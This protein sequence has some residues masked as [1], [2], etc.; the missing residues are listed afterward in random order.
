M[1]DQKNYTPYY[2]P[3]Q[4]G[5][6]QGFP[7]AEFSIGETPGVPLDATGASRLPVGN[8]CFA[9]GKASSFAGYPIIP[10]PV[11]DDNRTARSEAL[12]KTTPADGSSFPNLVNNGLNRARHTW[13]RVQK[14]A[15]GRLMSFMN[16][17]TGKNK[18]LFRLDL[19]SAP[20]CGHALREN[21]QELR[22]EIENTFGLR[23]NYVMVE[24]TEGHGVLHMVLAI[25]HR[26]L[27]NRSPIYIPKP[28]ISKRW[29]KITGGSFVVMIAKIGNFNR[30]FR[31]KDIL[32]HH[33]D[34]SK[35]LVSQ[36]LAD[37]G[38][39]F[40]RLSWSWYRGQM[41]LGREF[42]HFM[43]LAR[44]GVY[45]AGE[46]LSYLKMNRGELYAGWSD[47]LRY[48]FWYTFKDRYFYIEDGIVHHLATGSCS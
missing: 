36:Y 45:K 35:Y 37:Q 7:Q 30:K 23:I 44:R 3:R 47:L 6:G 15:Y 13:S 48:G 11:S 12:A 25:S 41:A 38:S 29:K 21:F 27:E 16:Y 33:K 32:S 26:R 10:L 19:T 14:R 1:A 42:T 28:W 5:S 4:D 22:R 20:G 43:S 17:Y 8:S 2:N 40:N 39:A 46:G 31:K 9:C 18:T 34:V 24:T